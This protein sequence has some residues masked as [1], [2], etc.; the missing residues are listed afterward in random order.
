[1]NAQPIDRKNVKQDDLERFVKN[2]I[3][4][5]YFKSAYAI[6]KMNI[7]DIK[8]QADSVCI[9]ISEISFYYC[10]EDEAEEFVKELCDKLSIITNNNISSENYQINGEI[11]DDDEEDDLGYSQHYHFKSI[12]IACEYNI[13]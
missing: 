6:G 5:A 4:I 8:V 9:K 3:E 10:K 11:I 13:L 12:Y 7:N 1:M 2:Q